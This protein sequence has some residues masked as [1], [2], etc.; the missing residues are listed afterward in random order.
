MSATPVSSNNKFNRCFSPAT[1]NLTVIELKDLSMKY[2]GR[3]NCH[4]VEELDR[5]RSETGSD[6]VVAPCT[7]WIYDSSDGFISMTS[8]VAIDPPISQRRPLIPCQLFQLNWVCSQSWR[9]TVGQSIFFVGCVF[10]VLFGFLADRIG[11]LPVLILANLTAM[12]GSLATRFSQDLLTFSTARFISGMATDSN[13]VMM[14]ILVLEY[15]RPS[16]RTFGLNI[17]IGIF[18]CVGSVL[19]PLIA[20]ELGNWRLFLLVTAIPIIVVPSFWFILPESIHWLVTTNKPDKALDMLHRVALFNGRTL[21]EKFNDEFRDEFEAFSKTQEANCNDK[22]LDT[23]WGLFKTP[24]LRRNMM[25]LFF[26]S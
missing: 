7:S 23:L 5:E 13:F 2:A 26:K 11:R 6:L 15:L 16:A 25:I 24:R 4:K 1:Q 14:Y 8:E 22:E 17:C 3:L 19:T 21:P 20:L 9:S 18:Y 12:L 10:G